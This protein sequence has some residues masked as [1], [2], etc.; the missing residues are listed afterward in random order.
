MSEPIARQRPIINLDEFERRLRQPKAA[1]SQGKDDPLNELARLVGDQDPYFDSFQERAPQ[2]RGQ[3]ERQ[4]PP[5]SFQKARPDPRQRPPQTRPAAAAQAPARRAPDMPR[6]AASTYDSYDQAPRE[7]GLRDPGMRDQALRSER[8]VGGQRPQNPAPGWP[9]RP[10]SRPAQQQPAPSSLRSASAAA[11]ARNFGGDFAAIEAGLRGS[12]QPDYRDSG[13]RQDY[14]QAPAE[15]QD[16]AQ[17]YRRAP[18]DSYQQDYRQAYQQQPADEDEDDDWLQQAQAPAAMPRVVAQRQ[19]SRAPAAAAAASY[20]PPQSR[21]LLYVTAAIVLVGMGGIGVVFASKHSSVTPQQIAMIKASTSPAKIQAPMPN[22]APAAMQ[23]DSVFDKTPSPSPTGVVN[24]AEQPVDLPQTAAAPPPPAAPD[25][26]AQAM[27]VPTPATEAPPWATAQNV[28]QGRVQPAA[29]PQV[30]A[31]A[32]PAPAPT[33]NP[34]AAS[35]RPANA[36]AQDPAPNQGGYGLGGVAARKVKTIAVR[37]DG[38]LATDQSAEARQAVPPTMQMP[39]GTQGPATASAGAGADLGSLAP[40]NAPKDA[41][42]EPADN[43][44]GTMSVATDTPPADTPP[45]VA[46]SRTRHVA[47][48]AKP[49]KVADLGD[50]APAAAAPQGGPQGGLDG[51]TPVAHATGGAAG[52]FAVQLAAPGSEAEA[53]HVMSKLLHDY[54][55]ELDGY[56][57]H[58]HHAKVGDKSVYRV[59]V[60]GLAKTAAV[61][62]CQSLQAKGGSCFIAKD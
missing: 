29:D 3:F 1:P 59:R 38:S 24:R 8:P 31:A 32:Q 19:Q 21:R 20:E 37:P 4:A 51:D 49:V 25:Q 56:Q 5:P 62:L 61:K 16:Y 33:P 27:P 48:H 60:G 9:E 30:Q 36:Q 18:V 44:S 22:D 42:A 23:D 50:T 28:P 14:R 45:V 12:L 35:P 46:P 39:A 58:M 54:G 13:Y 41:G 15:R 57:L 6:T 43:S 10:A 34:Q 52:G 26:D 7:Q 2:E 17:D 53:R 11:Q 40:A 55:T 47:S